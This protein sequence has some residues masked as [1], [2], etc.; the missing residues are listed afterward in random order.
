VF[1]Q[2]FVVLR[3]PGETLRIRSAPLGTNPGPDAREA[4]RRAS[5][6]LRF[7]IEARD[8]RVVE[9]GG[10]LLNL[11]DRSLQLRD[12]ARSLGAAAFRNE[13]ARRLASELER[14]RL[15]AEFFT[16]TPLQ[17]FDEPSEVELPPLPPP[18]REGPETFYEVR[19]VDEIGQAVNGVAVDF[20]APGDARNVT[21]N[22][23][24]VALI[25]G[26]KSFSATVAVPDLDALEQQL[27]PR[28]R[29][30]RP[31]RFPKESNQTAV[32]LDGSP[33]GPISVRAAVPNTVVIQPVI[34]DLLLELADKRSRIRHKKRP[35]KISGPITLSGETDE[36]GLVSHP[37]VP[38]GD[39]R[40]ELDVEVD[41]G[42]TEPKH[43]LFTTAAVVLAPSDETPQFRGLGALPQALLLRLR[44]LVFDTNKAFLLP[45][46]LPS[47]GRLRQ[48]L[49][50][51]TPGKLLIVGHTDTTG[52]PDYNEKLSL[53]RARSMAAFL[54]DDVAKWLEFYETKLPKEQRWGAHED[55]QM[56]LSMPDFERKPAREDPIRWFQR[57]RLL[58]IDGVAGPETRTQLIK[59]Y[60]QR[61]G[62]SLDEDPELDLEITCH[63]CGEN[64]P[65]DDGGE[66]LDE[67]P[68]DD[69]EDT[70]DRRVE[71]YLFDPEF[72]IEPPPPGELSKAGST[73]YPA[74][75]TRSELGL[76]LEG[77]GRRIQIR[78][79]DDQ[80]TA[81]DG[82][83]YRVR[84]GRE[85]HLGSAKDGVVDIVS[86]SAETRCLLEWSPSGDEPLPLAGGNPT[87]ASQ[88]FVTPVGAEDPETAQRMLQNLGYASSFG[89]ADAVLAFQSD[90]G[91]DETG[92][93]DEATTARLDD[94]YTELAGI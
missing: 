25:E 63:G 43:E 90:Q 28:W 11:V 67:A 65:L 29:S 3:S 16:E 68:A 81:Q 93:L 9:A 86:A 75:R 69:Q 59:E 40:L 45:S 36:R 37:R 39:Y 89:L 66:S 80:D 1:E 8:P 57:T 19:F 6:L 61:D 7:G 17:T 23:G 84:I 91:L 10:R 62:V 42:E 74:W 76:D 34:G 2:D 12:I 51:H 85:I 87:H 46:A 27:D 18:R 4:S 53:T 33:I 35:Y 70:L 77:T 14:G 55:A 32:V 54:E 71:L 47:L 24:G 15:V 94:V 38:N 5:A 20:E 73:A 26:V 79:L 78:I 49:L 72:G 83:E 22:T 60:M 56:L 52:E 30:I 50:A 92:E 58:A 82:A 41:I 48:V 64:F 31:G 21:S 88:V 13:L 44:G